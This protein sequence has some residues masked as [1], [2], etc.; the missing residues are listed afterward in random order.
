MVHAGSA[1]ILRD[2]SSRIG[3]KAAEANVPVSVEIYDGMPHVFQGGADT[4]EAKVSMQR[5]G[6]FIRQHAGRATATAAQ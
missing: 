1:E 6:Q 4:Q 5:L 2:D 3:D